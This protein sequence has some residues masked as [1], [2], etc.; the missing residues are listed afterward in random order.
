MWEDVYSEQF[1]VMERLR[2]DGGWLYRNRLVTSGSAQ[3]PGDY[4]WLVSMSFVPGEPQPPQNLAVP[5]V[6][7]AGATLTCTMG[8]W[9]GTPTAYAYQWQSDGANVGTAGEATYT[10]LPQDVGHSF[11]CIVIATNAAGQTAAPVSNAVV[12]GAP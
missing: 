4:V 11:A 8:E 10:V 1:D 2:V 6:Q 7:Q 3:D 12:V 5:M 9:I